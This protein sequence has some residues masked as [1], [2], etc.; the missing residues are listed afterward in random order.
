VRDP[1]AAFLGEGFDF[2]VRAGL[3][4][5]WVDGDPPQGPAVW[6]ANHHSWWDPFIAHVLFRR[7]GRDGGLVMDDDNLRAV[8]FLRRLGVVGTKELDTAVEL[9]RRGRVVVMFP[10]GELL[11]AGPPGP[12][13]RGAA[14]LAV[15]APA[16]LLAAAV[17]VSVRGHQAPEAYVRVR[18]VDCAGGADAA[19]GRLA[20]VLRVGL[21]EIDAAVASTDP[22]SPL[23]GY[24]RVVKGRRS[25]DERIAPG[26]GE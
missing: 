5:V 6:A 17:R 25:W 18:P 22:R 16:S 4:G 12:L 7:A 8:G 1:V 2:M 11:P 13:R 19:T 3:R 24:L 23:P 15:D 26:L 20:E 10:E 14:R 21:A 9:I